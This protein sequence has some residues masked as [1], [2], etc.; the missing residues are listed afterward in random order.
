MQVSWN[1][2]SPLRR[3]ELPRNLFGERSGGRGAIMLGTSS[4]DP[5][6]I[7]PEF[8]WCCCWCWCWAQFPRE[9]RRVPPLGRVWCRCD[10]LLRIGRKDGGWGE[11]RK[12]AR[13][14][15]AE[16]GAVRNCQQLQSHPV[17]TS[18][19]PL[20][21]RFWGLLTLLAM[22]ADWRPR[23]DPQL[24]MH[25]L[26]RDTGSCGSRCKNSGVPGTLSANLQI[27]GG[28]CSSSAVQSRAE[29]R[30][31]E[32]DGTLEG[33]TRL[34]RKWQIQQINQNQYSEIGSQY[35]LLNRYSLADSRQ[36]NWSCPADFLMPWWPWY[37]DW[38]MWSVASVPDWSSPAA[39]GCCPSSCA[40]WR[41]RIPG[42]RTASPGCAATWCHCKSN[43]GCLGSSI[44]IEW[45]RNGVSFLIWTYQSLRMC[46]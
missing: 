44:T 20:N 14:A 12:G 30:K 27:A 41:S 24:R 32:E 11:K 31:T 43:T 22:S 33:L 8:C 40:A 6:P 9:W 36:G 45:M 3:W 39:G 18:P 35:A 25:L 7:A 5:S 34:H 23:R 37:P 42:W 38:R 19:S 2:N 1:V 46:L 21:A 10:L 26:L 29:M 13:L 28:T 4:G 17:I 15:W 16:K